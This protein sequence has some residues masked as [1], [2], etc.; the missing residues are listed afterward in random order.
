MLR[1]ALSDIGGRRLH[2]EERYHNQTEAE[3]ATGRQGGGRFDSRGAPTATRRSGKE[4]A[5]H[6]PLPGGGGCPARWRAETTRPGPTGA[7]MRPDT[8][9]RCRH[10]PPIAPSS[11]GRVVTVHERVESG[12]RFLDKLGM[13]IGWG[14]KGAVFEGGESRTIAGGWGL[15]AGRFATM[16]TRPAQ[17]RGELRR[18]SPRPGLTV[19]ILPALVGQP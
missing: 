12:E 16:A 18:V 11:S 9:P 8:R 4:G 2:R 1:C 13:T 5:C 3:P 6:A 17:A 14:R 10:C 7:S 15:L 19:L